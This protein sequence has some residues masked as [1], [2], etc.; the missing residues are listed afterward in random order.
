MS[1]KYTAKFNGQ[2]FVRRSKRDASRPY[3][4][5]IIARNNRAYAKNLAEWAGQD[6]AD[7]WVARTDFNKY[8]VIAWAGRPDLALKKIQEISTLPDWTDVQAIPTEEIA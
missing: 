5:C 1:I 8:H 3:S 6:K 2:T 7:A 4:H